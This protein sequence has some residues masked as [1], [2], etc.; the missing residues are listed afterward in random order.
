M[1]SE[2]L[3]FDTET[4]DLEDPVLIEASGIYITGNPLKDEQKDYFTE[5]YNPGKPITI[6]AMSKHHI[7]DSDLINC[8][9]Y[10]D[11]KL[12]PNVKYLIG[13]N[14]D[15]DWKVI[16]C[17]DVKRID[18]LAISRYLWPDLQV[19]TLVGLIYFINDD[20]KKARELVK[21]A[22]S[23]LA[24]CWMVLDLLKVIIKLNKDKIKNWEDLYQFSE[25][26]R[27]PNVMPFGKYKGELISEIPNDYK[28]W[29]L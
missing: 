11:F 24:D 2:V 1:S 20:K 15:F 12:D 13:H 19:H 25:K 3:I 9:P 14:I 8:K 22:H 23:S 6:E 17:P 7:I 5:R 28:I 26:C 29:L 10:T 27:I 4:T 18:T 16:G 21:N